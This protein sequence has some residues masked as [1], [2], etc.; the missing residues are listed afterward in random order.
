MNRIIIFV[1]VSI[2]I[3]IISWRTLYKIKSH[4]FFR[5]FSWECIVWLFVSNYR[6]WFDNPLSITQLFSW[7]LLFVSGYLVIAGMMKL[8]EKG[9]QE[10]NSNRKTL[11]PFEQTTEL[12]E[13]GIY[14]YVRHPLYS[15]LLFLTWGIFLKN[16]TIELLVV[17]ILSSTFLYLTAIFDEKECIIF[18]GD[19]YTEYMK[20]SK[21]FLPY[22]L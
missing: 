16:T 3:T 8:K 13:T 15:S 14:K 12:I 17:T 9:K 7:S 1:I 20:R 19:K 21:R 11:Y 4:G 10:R 18:F 22:I 5:Y 6:Y 2:P